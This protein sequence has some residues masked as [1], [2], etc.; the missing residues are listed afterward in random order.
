[1][2]PQQADLGGVM[3]ALLTPFD[4]THRV[5]Y[6]ALETE[7][8]FAI[9][10]CRSDAL[11]IAAVEAAEYSMLGESARLELIA[12]GTEIA[13]GRVPL[14]A[15]VSHPSPNIVRTWI[16]RVAAAG[17][18][19]AQV[20]MPQRPWGGEPTKTELVSY[21]ELVARDSPLPL[22]VYHN[23]ATGADPAT[24]V[25][26]EIA[27]LPAV[28]AFKESSRDISKIALL[29]ELIDRAG[30]ARYLTTMQP[31]LATLMLGGSGA[32]MPPPAAFVGS[33]IVAAYRAGDHASAVRWQRLFSTFPRRWA[34]YGLPPVMKA[35]MSHLGVAIGEPHPPYAGMSESDRADLTNWLD[36]VGLTAS[37][38]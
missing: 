28:R 24:D 3:T 1:M 33:E 26:A 36:E 38:R 7:I 37:L 18:D 31:M 35:A 15:G 4:A 13:A 9:G 29:I 10:R 11:T 23:P 14:I 5:D 2:T 19:Y 12:R 30:H 25:W 34:K 22:V 20:L 17:A 16:E 6:A 32:T 21:F 8:E 27:L